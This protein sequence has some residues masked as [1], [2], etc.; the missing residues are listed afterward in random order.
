MNFS[1]LDRKSFE[2]GFMFA[3]FVIEHLKGKL[4]LDALAAYLDDIRTG[5][6][7]LMPSPLDIISSIEKDVGKKLPDNLR[8]SVHRMQSSRSETDEYNKLA[9]LAILN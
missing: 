7:S 3:S 6:I 2:A 9:A 4:D 1:E 8:E 5:A